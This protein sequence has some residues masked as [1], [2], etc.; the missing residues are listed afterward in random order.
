MTT[1]DGL[2]ALDALTGLKRLPIES[3][4][5]IVTS[6]PYWDTRDYGPLAVK[7]ADDERCVLGREPTIEQYLVH[8]LEVFDEIKRVVKLSGTVWVNLGDVYW[9]GSRCVQRNT[10]GS[11]LGREPVEDAGLKSDRQSTRGLA[12]DPLTLPY[13]SLCL[14]PER[15]ALAMVARG[16][17]L[18]NR[19]VWHKPNH[20]PASVKDR[21]ACTWEHLFLF[22]KSSSYTFDLDAIRVPHQ[23]QPHQNPKNE[24][25]RP[26][27]CIR[28]RRLPPRAGEPQAMH[29]MG[30]NP[31]DCWSIPL[32]PSRHKHAA[33]FPEALCVRP[34]LAGSPLR[35]IVLDP[36]VGS[37]TTAVVAKRL[38]RGFIG[39]DSNPEYIKMAKLRLSKSSENETTTAQ[40]S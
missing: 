27:K 21:L 11:G 19:I 10:T 34:I 16:W 35:G 2:H 20:L 14:I 18:R 12:S 7:W 5:C 8:L 1:F 22:T 3:V 36:F 31:G 37:G 30:K 6:P 33:A 4:D 28:G 29:P 9:S 32:R 26:S 40:P 38:G 17:V 24:S 39:F 25:V 23:S 13:K 15:F